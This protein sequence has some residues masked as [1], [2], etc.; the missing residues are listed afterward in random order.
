MPDVNLCRDELHENHNP[1][2]CGKARRS[3][4][5]SLD[6]K[7]QLLGWEAQHVRIDTVVHQVAWV[8]DTECFRELHLACG[9]TDLVDNLKSPHFVS[10]P[11]TCLGCLAHPEPPP[12]CRPEWRPKIKD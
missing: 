12:T 3:D 4:N 2:R 1:R 9:G 6:E 5:A 11:V 7:E 8:N 10:T